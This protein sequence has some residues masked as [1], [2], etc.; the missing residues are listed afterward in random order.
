MYKA[1]CRIQDKA[2]V[3]KRK[4]SVHTSDKAFSHEEAASYYKY[5]ASCHTQGNMYHHP[6]QDL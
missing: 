2:L 1:D 3:Y 6:N 5:K 4:E